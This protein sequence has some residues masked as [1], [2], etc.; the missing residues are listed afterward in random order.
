MRCPGG[1]EGSLVIT[2]LREDEC[3]ENGNAITGLTR[4]LSGCP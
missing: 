4:P 2:L 3:D 1:G